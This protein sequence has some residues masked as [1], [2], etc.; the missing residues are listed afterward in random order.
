M[1]LLLGEDCTLSGKV[2]E[3]VQVRISSTGGESEIQL[4]AKVP[5]FWEVPGGPGFYT[6]NAGGTGLI[7]GQGTKIPHAAWCDQNKQKSSASEI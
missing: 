4:E 1:P 3:M 6:A 7:P 2:L 5:S